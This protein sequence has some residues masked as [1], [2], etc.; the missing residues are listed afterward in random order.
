MRTRV[1]LLMFRCF[2]AS[3]WWS[4]IAAQALTLT[5]LVGAAVVDRI[6]PFGTQGVACEETSYDS[7]S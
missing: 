1:E 2:Y 3:G 6:D 7:R 5:A 4:R